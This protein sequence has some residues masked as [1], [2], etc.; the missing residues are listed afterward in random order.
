M[1][2]VLAS[3]NRKKIGEMLTLLSAQ[4]GV[5]EGVEILSLADIGYEDE[6]VEN[7]ETF[8]ENAITKASVPASLGYIGIADDSGITV[9]ALGGRPGVY[10]ARYAGEPCDDEKN[11]Q[12]LLAELA[13]VEGDDRSAHYVCSIACVFPDGRTVTAEKSCDGIILKEYHGNGGFGYDPLFYFPS[14]GKTFGELTPEEKHSV[15]HR[16]KAIA[17][18][19]KK[20]NAM[21]EKSMLPLTS[22]E[23]AYLRSLSN[24]MSPIFQI[25][26]GGI[27]RETCRQIGNALEARELI[28]VSVLENS[29]YS[30]REAAELLAIS[31]SAAVVSVV[32][33]KFVLYRPSKNAQKIVLP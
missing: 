28:K 26:K 27:S 30:A 23:R 1:K 29:V 18:F 20:F 10:S 7:G 14:F 9:D 12:K 13:D 32:G 3:R 21:A 16:G 11:N 15:S 22:K 6:I 17:A 33:R 4:G 24:G 19:A 2:L 8:R 31:C 25:G 5:L